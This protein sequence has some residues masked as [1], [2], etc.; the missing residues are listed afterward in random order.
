MAIVGFSGVVR[1]AR[2]ACLLAVAVLAAFVFAGASGTA[3]ASTSHAKGIDVSNWNGT[4]K[5]T[6][7]A[8]AG[9]RFVLGKATEGTTFED[10]TYAANRA[11]SEAAGVVFGAYDFARPSG[12]S[13]AAVTASATAQ[14]DYFLAS[15]PRSPAS[16]RPRSI[17]RRRATCPPACSKHGRRR[18][19]RRSTRASASTRS[20]TRHPPSGRSTS[21]TRRRSRRPARRSGSRTGRARASRWVPAAELERPGL[22]VLAVDRLRLGARHRPLRRRRPHERSE[23]RVARDR[24]VLARHADALDPAEHRRHS[25]SRQAPLA[26]CRASGTAGSRSPSRSSG[27]S[28]TPRAR[29]A[30]T[31]PARRESRTGRQAA[32]SATR[33]GCASPR[34]PPRRPRRRT[35]RRRSPSLRPAPRRAHVPR[36]STRRSSSERSRSA[37][38]SPAR[39]ERGRGSRRSS[40]TAGSAV[41]RA[42]STASPSRRRRTRRTRRRPTIWARRSPS[43]SRLQAQAVPPPPFRPD[44]GR[45]RRAAAAALD[46]L[47]GGRQGRRRERRDDRRPRDRDVAAGRRPRRPHGQPRQLRPGPRPS[48]AAVSRS[49]F[50]VSRAPAS[51]GLS[52][53]TTRPRRPHRRV[54]G[55]SHRRQS[56]R[57]AVP[58]L[59]AAAAAERAD[60]RRVLR[61]ATG[62]HTS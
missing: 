35:R 2:L 43:S 21:P 40:R 15:R 59:D 28:A 55:Y 7:V 57:R 44:Q 26:P 32:T 6:K 20:S 53:S 23:P 22:D 12:S 19:R 48:P 39:P 5:W 50:P 13:I 47:A 4:I 45:R 11:G 9:Y 10:G 34:P 3:E 49:A 25:R 27:A 62:R 37:R 18:G 8:H 31:S 33:S 29:T 60:G 24:A 38:S 54:L 51:S 52:R 17:S 56:L 1:C 14:A 30:S 61:S 41:T 16:C 46:R 58:A 42:G 36:T